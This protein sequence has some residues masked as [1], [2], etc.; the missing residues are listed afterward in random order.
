VVH[1]DE[2]GAEDVIEQGAE[3]FQVQPELGKRETERCNA[4]EA[5]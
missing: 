3:F 4:A 1:V 5:R 2:D